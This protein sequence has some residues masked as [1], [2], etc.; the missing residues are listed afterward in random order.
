MTAT[1]TASAKNATPMKKMKGEYKLYI[2]MR[3][4]LPSLNAG[5]AMAQAA[6]A[7]NA[8]TAKWGDYGFVKDYSNRNHPFGTCIVLGVDKHTLVSRLEKAQSLEWTIPWGSVVDETYPFNTN[9]EIAALIPKSRMTAPPILKE[10]NRVVLFRRELTCGY[11]LVADG[12]SEQS[13]LVGD[14][15]LY[16]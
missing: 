3:N 13:E 15:S 2:L 1:A 12:S 4:D 16:Q 11:M 7:A 10:D 9:T 14:L 6:H 5:K 8:L